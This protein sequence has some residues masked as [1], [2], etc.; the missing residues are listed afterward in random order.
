MTY[1]DSII[2][3]NKDIPLLSRVMWIMQDIAMNEKKRGFQND[4]K[5]NITQHLSFTPGAKGNVN[6]IDAIIS[7]LSELDSKNEALTREYMDDLRTAERILN[8]ITSYTMRVF[9]NMRY[10]FNMPKKTIKR[11][12]CLS[13]WGFERAVRMIED[14]PD[15]ASVKWQERYVLIDE[16]GHFQ[17]K[18]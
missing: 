13:K 4:L 10:V 9:V 17:K 1:Q 3:R 16:K 2:V 7:E 18:T 11:E 15:M 14:A 6:G 5:Y 8:S 12:L